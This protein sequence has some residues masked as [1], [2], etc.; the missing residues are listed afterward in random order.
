MTISYMR[1]AAHISTSEGQEI[2]NRIVW[3]DETT[4]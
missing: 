4:R 2:D 1:G 3:A